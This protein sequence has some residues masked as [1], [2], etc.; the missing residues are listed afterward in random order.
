MV[1]L[2]ALGSRSPYEVVTG[3]K[4]KLPRSLEVTH[5][6]EHVDVE[7]YSRRLVEYFRETYRSVES[8]QREAL[9]AKG[10]ALDG[11]LSSELQVGDVVAFRREASVR[12]EGPLRFQQ[13][14]YPDL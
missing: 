4:P 11:H 7:E 8:V 14:T 10:S 9:E 3:L 6:I 12:R 5:V 1:P 2:K 13:R